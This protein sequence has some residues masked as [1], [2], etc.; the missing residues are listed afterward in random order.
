[1][2]QMLRVLNVVKAQWLHLL[3]TLLNDTE[4]GLVRGIH[5]Q[6][7]SDAGW[8]RARRKEKTEPTSLSQ[9]SSSLGVTM[10]TSMFVPI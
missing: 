6:R 1:M 9:G 2:I 7:V 5:G 4:M 8:Q 10:R 3:V